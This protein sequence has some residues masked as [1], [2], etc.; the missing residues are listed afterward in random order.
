MK[1]PETN[2]L[3]SNTNL[4]VGVVRLRSNEDFLVETEAGNLSCRRA[5]SCLTVPRPG[6]LT[7]LA[8]HGAKRAWILSVLEKAESGRTVINI[9][10][11][12]EIRTGDRGIKL[13]GD[14]IDLAAGREIRNTSPRWSVITARGEVKSRD[15]SLAAQTLSASAS[16]IR[17]WGDVVESRIEK[18]IERIGHAFRQV[19]GLD[20]LKAGRVRTDVEEAWDLS[21]ENTRIT[22]SDKVRVDAEKIDLG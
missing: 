20:K 13:S 22:A 21:A 3:P 10:E 19:R 5:D 8:V 11:G 17:V 2:S 12:L 4:T 15:L 9:P 7:L 14:H 16:R 1:K 6:D 18:L